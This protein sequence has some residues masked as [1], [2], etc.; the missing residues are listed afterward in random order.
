MINIWLYTVFKMLYILNKKIRS[1]CSDREN[2]SIL[3][4]FKNWLELP[5]SYQIRHL[6]VL[7]YVIAGWRN[8]VLE[9]LFC[10][11]LIKYFAL[12]SSYSRDWHLKDILRAQSILFTFLHKYKHKYWG[13]RPR[14][15]LYI[16]VRQRESLWVDKDG[17]IAVAYRV[18]WC[19][20]LLQ[21]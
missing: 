15:H 2:Y 4:F 9:G 7:L 1:S 11:W 6:Q 20:Q 5:K 14:R 3:S 19:T 12:F 18:Q 17:H 16:S 10:N 13:T 21:P 8:S